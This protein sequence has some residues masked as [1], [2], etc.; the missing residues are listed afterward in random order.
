[1]KN[2][3]IWSVGFMF[4]LY[5][6]L[7]LQGTT[8]IS[9]QQGKKDNKNALIPLN[10]SKSL[11]YEWNRTWGGDNGD[12]G[13][14]VAVD[15]SS[16]MYVAGYTES[17]GAGNDDMILIKYDGMGAQQWNRTW[18]GSNGDYGE[19]VAVDSSD[20]LYVVGYT[21]SFGVGNGDLVL[22][23]YDE[24]GVQQWNRTWGGEDDDYGFGVAVDSSG[25]VY[26][27]GYIYS[28]GAGDYDIV[29]VKY[30][31]MGAQQ[32]NRTWGGDKGDH[33]LGLT[34]DS[35][36]NVYVAGITWSFG[37]GWYDMILVKYEGMGMQQW[38]CTWGGGE[39]D[40]GFGVAVDS[41]DNVYL[42]GHTESFGAVGADIV[43]LKY[44]GIG[45]QQWNSIWS[46]GNVDICFGVTV[47]SPGNVY[48]TGSTRSFGA[49]GYDVVVVKYVPDIYNPVITINSPQPNDAFGVDAP[50]FDI[51]LIEPNLNSTW[52]T[53][54]NDATNI[55]FTGLNGTINQDEWQKKSEGQITITFYA[56]D[57]DGNTGS[58]F[59]IVRKQI[60][61]TIPLELIL[62]ILIINGGAVIGIATILLIRRKRKR[63]Q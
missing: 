31:G 41:A 33:G 44:D 24:M 30:D 39:D 38:N 4:I 10:S 13:K 42:A 16:N 18:G 7:L 56:R 14:A 61:L 12:C 48:L 5:F 54:D 47:D 52:Y 21:K 17:F 9:N 57:Y 27:A 29:L 43:L 36:G 11:V 45:L 3:K 59:V 2:I 58:S 62:I 8:I 25:N 60:G 35:S 1:M 53:L 46:G 63:I 32:W 19:G 55:T 51:S 22:V 49:G 26:V 15:S 23:K 20:N 6:S 37:A 34:V 40:Y 28:F 50:N